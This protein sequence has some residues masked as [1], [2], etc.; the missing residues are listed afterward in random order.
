MFAF[1]KEFNVISLSSVQTLQAHLYYNHTHGHSHV[2]TVMHVNMHAKLKHL[3]CTILKEKSESGSSPTT[4]N[5]KHQQ[6]KQFKPCTVHPWL[7]PTDVSLCNVHCACAATQSSTR[8][9]HVCCIHNIEGNFLHTH[10]HTYTNTTVGYC[11]ACA[12]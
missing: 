10:T 11:Y 5:V 6:Q 3:K 8:Q 9:G 7:M 2:A 1:H 12:H 4:L